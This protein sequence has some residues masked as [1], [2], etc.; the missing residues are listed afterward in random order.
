MS[1]ALET[2]TRTPLAQENQ[3]ERGYYSNV[4]NDVTKTGSS[5]VSSC[6]T[7]ARVSTLYC[8]TYVSLINYVSFN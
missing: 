7:R 2:N 6:L 3:A 8:M 4:T 1:L 5:I